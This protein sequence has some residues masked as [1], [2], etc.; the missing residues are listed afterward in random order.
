MGSLNRLI[1]IVL[2]ATLESMQI[3]TLH[4]RSLMWLHQLETY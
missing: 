4:S 2:L 1:Q 3:D